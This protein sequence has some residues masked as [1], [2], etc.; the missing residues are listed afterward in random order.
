[1][2]SVER[3]DRKMPVIRDRVGKIECGHLVAA[4]RKQ[5]S[6]PTIAAAEL[7]EMAAV[8]HPYE[9][10]LEFVAADGSEE[11]KFLHHVP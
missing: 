10:T 9:R 2:P 4:V 11:R 1:M 8:R 6:L 7:E 5:S 3:I